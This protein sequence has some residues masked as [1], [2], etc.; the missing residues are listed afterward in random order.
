MYT[1]LHVSHQNCF[2]FLKFQY[3]LLDI[4]IFI[5]NVFH[6]SPNVRANLLKLVA[7]QSHL[8]Y[9]IIPPIEIQRLKRTERKKKAKQK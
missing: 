3:Y 7:Y 5:I 9:K 2:K 4:C 1:Y 8:K 6:T